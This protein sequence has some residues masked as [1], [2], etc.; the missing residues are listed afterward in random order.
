MSKQKLIPPPP[1]VRQK[2]ARHIR[3]V[4]L[5]RALLRV[6]IRDAE[7]HQRETHAPRHEPARREEAAR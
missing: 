4:R 3:E 6:S 1:V 2:L 7:E 5:L